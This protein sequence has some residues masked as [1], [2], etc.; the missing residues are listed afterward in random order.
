MRRILNLRVRT[1]E[2]S[3]ER[4]VDPPIQVHQPQVVQLLLPR[5]ALVVDSRLDVSDRS[6]DRRAGRGPSVA[7]GVVGVGFDDVAGLV[8]DDGDAAQV[9]VMGP[10]LDRAWAAGVVAVGRID[11]QPQSRRPVGFNGRAADAISCGNVDFHPFGVVQGHVAARLSGALLRDALVFRAV[12][13]GAGVAGIAVGDAVGHV[14]AGPVAVGA[15]TL[16]A[17]PCPAEQVAVGVVVKV[18]DAGDGGHRMRPRAADAVG[19]KGVACAVAVS[20]LAC[21]DGAGAVRT[22]GG[23]A[24]VAAAY[25]GLAGDVAHLVVAEALLGVAGAEHLA[26]DQAVEVVVAKRFAVVVAALAAPFFGAVVDVAQDVVL[27]VFMEDQGVGADVGDQ[28]VVQ[29]FGV[30][31]VVAREV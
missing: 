6:G 29:S 13:E 30:G 19:T 31:V 10:A 3:H 8:A 21:R 5:K 4:I 18:A 16:V 14:E 11:L 12:G 23:A 20:L 22:A 28:A 15:G 24:A 17:A 2:S 7:P 26:G 25:T 1:E 9:V 27:V